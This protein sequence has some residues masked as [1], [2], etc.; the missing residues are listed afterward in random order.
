[1]TAPGQPVTAA[2]RPASA[3]G[4]EVPATC[5]AMVPV[6]TIKAGEEFAP[7]W[8][9]HPWGWLPASAPEE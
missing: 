5:C 3:A 8:G 9:T 2:A 6:R 4:P 7:G 1:M